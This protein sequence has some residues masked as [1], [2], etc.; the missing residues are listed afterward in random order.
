MVSDKLAVLPLDPGNNANRSELWI[1]G[2][3]GD[4][5]WIRQL[6][7]A[8]HLLDEVE[9]CEGLPVEFLTVGLGELGKELGPCSIMRCVTTL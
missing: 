7:C 9:L 5:L 1:I 2:V 3:S 6:V 8:L 4:Q